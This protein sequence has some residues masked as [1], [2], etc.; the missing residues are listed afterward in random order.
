MAECT[1]F[2]NRNTPND[3]LPKLYETLIDLVENKHV[4][5]FMVGD[6]GNFDRLVLKCLKML[7]LDYPEISFYIVLAYSPFSER[8]RTE[9]YEKYAVYPE[10]VGRA[11]PRYAIDIRNRYMIREAQY[12]VTYVRDIT[13]GARKFKDLSLKHKRN[14][15][16]LYEPES[17]SDS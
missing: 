7:K 16:E 3:I 6:E 5:F 12:V 15:I 1:F 2:G 10:I 8:Y 9:D 13:G 14:V 11:C 4:N 17:R